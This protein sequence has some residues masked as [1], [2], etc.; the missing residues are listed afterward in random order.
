M[1]YSVSREIRVYDD[2][3]GGFLSIKD[4]SD[5]LGLAELC[6]VGS[7]GNTYARVVMKREEAAMLAAAITEWLRSSE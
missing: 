3:D 7:N 4:D 5:G 1:T 2:D 6:R